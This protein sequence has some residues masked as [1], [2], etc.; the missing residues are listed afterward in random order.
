MTGWFN[1]AM[2]YDMINASPWSC[3]NLHMNQLYD[4]SIAM[5]GMYMYPQYSFNNFMP[6]GNMMSNSYLTNPFYTMNQ[7][8]WGNSMYGMNMGMPGMYGM[9][10]GMPGMFGWGGGPFLTTGNGGGNGDSNLSA[11]ERGFKRKFNALLALVKQLKTYDGLTNPE[12]DELD[13]AARARKNSKNTYEEL[14]NDLSTAYN[15]INKDIVRTFLKE[16]GHNLGVKSDLKDKNG[17]DA[18]H[19]RL[20]GIG[21]E[22]SNVGA[23]AIISE[24]HDNI[25]KL[26]EKTGTNTDAE[27]AVLKALLG[28]YDIL[29][30]V[31]SWNSKYNSQSAKYTPLDHMMTHYAKIGDDDDQKTTAKNNIIK[32]FVDAM[33]VK[34]NSVKGALDSASQVSMEKAIDALEKEIGKSDLN[35]SSLVSAFN[36]VY[37][38]TRQ[39]ALMKL[40]NDAKGYYGEVDSAVFNDSLFKDDMLKDLKDSEGF[41][42]SEIKATEVK[43][44]S[45]ATRASSASSSS[46]SGS[47]PE[48]DKYD[49]IDTKSA[50]DAMK[51]LLKSNILEQTSVKFNGQHVIYAEPENTKSGISDGDGTPDYRRL[52]IIQ[53][54]KIKELKNTKLNSSGNGTEIANNNS[55]VAQEPQEIDP[56]EIIDA[57]TKLEEKQA[58]KEE[59]EEKISD[60]KE[61]G[62]DI[63]YYLAQD[64]GHG[65]W[66]WTGSS[67]ERTINTLLGEINSDNVLD[68]LEGFYAKSEHSNCGAA[69][70]KGFIEWVSQDCT[71][72]TEENKANVK[73]DT[74][75][76]VLDACITKFKNYNNDPIVKK[77]LNILEKSKEKW[78]A[79]EYDL[80][81][82]YDRYEDDFCE[83]TDSSVNTNIKTK[84][85]DTDEYDEIFDSCIIIIFDRIK[86]LE[87]KKK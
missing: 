28:T 47:E 71:V 25:E 19:E 11:E 60:A 75:I 34:A 42:E 39:A 56:S 61:I 78:I 43:L 85:A 58:E 83:W 7:M 12:K 48:E 44:S 74:I 82:D 30:F 16:H 18:F 67:E 14:F 66:N 86:E 10:M 23:D 31:S 36:K 57:K 33:L 55:G 73:N 41:S 81:A 87:S 3:M 27:G 64:W 50:S 38:F 84:Y 80:T 77:Y 65:T 20:I 8:S 13:V 4:H 9:N 46:S 76:T 62:E 22:L 53:D 35:K 26:S 17:K 6:Y 1:S 29:D 68:V 21:H 40:Q 45:S 59:V 69:G 79:A 72:G 52:F 15:K 51:I 24:F 2:T 37:L 54:G 63:H 32:P 5:Q 70:K 49:G